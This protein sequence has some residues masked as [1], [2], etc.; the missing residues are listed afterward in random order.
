L[1]IS[2]QGDDEFDDFPDPPSGEAKRDQFYCAYWFY[3]IACF[4][5]MKIL[6]RNKNGQCTIIIAPFGVIVYF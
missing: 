6:Y 3:P 5:K 1:F 4:S 2:C